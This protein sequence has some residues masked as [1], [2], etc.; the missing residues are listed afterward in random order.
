MQ[1]SWG[2]LSRKL[3]ASLH[4]RRKTTDTKREDGQQV[5]DTPQTP[6]VTRRT[7]FP[8]P[9][10]IPDR[11][12]VPRIDRSFTI[13]RKPLPPSASKHV[14]I[15][16]RT[17]TVARAG[18]PPARV[19]E[20]RPSA[21]IHDQPIARFDIGA[22]LISLEEAQQR[23]REGLL[24]VE[25]EPSWAATSN[26]YSTTTHHEE[27][28]LEQTVPASPGARRA[29]GSRIDWGYL[30]L[31]RH[32]GCATDNDEFRPE[33]KS[34]PLG[35]R[36]H[37]VHPVTNSHVPRGRCNGDRPLA[38]RI[39]EKPASNIIVFSTADLTE[40]L[41]PHPESWRK[42]R[43]QTRLAAVASAA[44]VNDIVPNPLRAGLRWSFEDPAD[45]RG[46]KEDE[47]TFSGTWVPPEPSDVSRA[48]T[49][50]PETYDGDSRTQSLDH[51]IASLRALKMG[52]PGI[53]RE[54]L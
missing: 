41:H 38:L 25:A 34:F 53:F 2:S 37:S 43:S 14:N 29:P 19:M 8:R 35:C 31:P 1:H 9:K 36:A 22:P 27:Y 17:Y 4:R 40:E 10:Q 47:T 21:L 39:Q 54:D 18:S 49:F 48:S 7:N 52:R 32:Q 12:P 33:K 20:Y 6:E 5:A 30:A 51:A 46:D 16:T 45:R 11:A 13:P 50:F 26:D 28:L 15:T 3:V 24:N 44:T 42:Q 23:Q